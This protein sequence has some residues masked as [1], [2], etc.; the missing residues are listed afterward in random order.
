MTGAIIWTHALAALLFGAAGGQPAAGNGMPRRA[1][2]VA[3]ATSALWALAAGIDARD[4]AA[5][6]AESV[7]NIAWLGFMLALIRRGRV[8]GWAPVLVHGV[9]MLVTLT[10]GLLE[11]AAAVARQAELATAAADTAILFRMLTAACALVLMRDLLA[12]ITGPGRG[13]VRLVAA[14]LT[15]LWA[16]NLLLYTIRYLWPEVMPSLATVRG[17]AMI[18]VA[19]LIWAGAR[20]GGD[21]VLSVSR[22]VAVRSVVLVALALYGGLMLLMT[23]LAARIWGEDARIAQTAIVFGATAALMTLATTPWLQSWVRVMVAKHLFRHRYDYRAEWQRFAETLGRPGE[24]ATPLP[25]RIVQAVAE[26][27]GSPAGLLLLASGTGATAGLTAGAAWNWAA[28]LAPDG[29]SDEAI[30]RHLAA[31]H[32]IV[33]LDEVRADTAPAPEAAAVPQWM[34]DC[35]DAWALVPLLHAEALVGAILLARPLVGRKLDWED[36]DLLRV[37]GRQAA[38]YLAED[39]AHAALADAHRFDEFNRRFAFILHDIKNVASQLSLVARNAERHADNPAFR[40]DMI[41]TLRSSAD[42]MTTLLARL[43]Q[44]RTPP[45]EPP[46]PTDVADLATRVAAERRASHPVVACATGPVWALVQGAR[47]EQVL[48]HLLQNAAEA[49]PAAEP[50]TLSVMPGEDGVVL[51]VFD[52]GCGMTP[53]FVRDQLFRPFVSTKP[54]GFGLGAHEARQLVEAMGGRLTVSSR[55]GEGTRFRIV[56]RPAPAWEAAA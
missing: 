21:W 47:L 38:S 55:E 39:R 9:L 5:R 8:R 14:A 48:R 31:T 2:A 51:E 45:A 7:C 1:F 26:L 37:A 34:V 28:G 33:E 24:D 12:A 50:V 35:K 32:R 53:A 40:A 6:L 23:G 36:L 30:A 44:Q 19:L 42:Q 29:G 56:L 11:V 27:T 13:G 3:L 25:P 22:T 49:S 54:G 17:V 52:Q 4:P 16:T 41:E 10:A 46:R 43:S 20:Q 15:G 18:P